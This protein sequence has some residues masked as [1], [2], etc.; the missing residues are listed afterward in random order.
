MLT[1]G[2]IIMKKVLSIIFTV[3][4]CLTLFSGCSDT[5]SGNDAKKSASGETGEKVQV[6]SFENVEYEPGTRTD[7]EYSNS[8]L[9]FKFDCGYEYTMTRDE[10]LDKMMDA[11]IDIAYEDSEEGKRVK[12]FA[13]ITTVY[14]MMA[15][16]DI[17][18]GSVLI[19]AE[20]VQ[21]QEIT[22]DQYISVL[23]TQLEN[24]ELKYDYKDISETELC[25]VVYTNLTYDVSADGSSYKQTM[26]IKRVG[27]RMV[28]ISFT[29]FDESDFD[30][31][32]E[33]FSKI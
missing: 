12:D 8:I 1:K 21:S 10:D 19:M 7:T 18:N 22:E 4:I 23:K 17:T 16:N 11:G 9:G 26:L 6:Q 32:L 25:G 13:D 27:D 3:A 24:T 2:E 20:K 28:V 14:E 31:M 33:S 15:M 5:S 30:D 29:Y